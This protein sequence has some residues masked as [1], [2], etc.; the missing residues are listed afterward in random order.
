MVHLFLICCDGLLSRELQQ[1]IIV[2]ART[3]IKMNSNKLIK[4]WEDLVR[5]ERIIP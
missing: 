4:T 1:A 3:K 5:R 2:K